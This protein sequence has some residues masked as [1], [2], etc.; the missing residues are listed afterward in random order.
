MHL[1]YR[2]ANSLNHVYTTEADRTH[3]AKWY[4]NLHRDMNKNTTSPVYLL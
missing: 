2:L 3:V 4:I 1:I